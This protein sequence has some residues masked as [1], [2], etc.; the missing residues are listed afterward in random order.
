MA[1]KVTLDTLEIKEPE[2]PLLE[3]TSPVGELDVKEAGRWPVLRGVL[4][5]ALALVMVI[6]IGGV[7]YWQMAIPKAALPQ[8]RRGVPQAPKL[9]EGLFTAKAN[10]FIV[11]I[12]DKKGE[13]RVLVCD[14]TFELSTGQDACFQQKILPVRKKIYELLKKASPDGTPGPGFRDGLKEE[15]NKA[16][17]GLLGQDTIKA[18]YFTKFVVL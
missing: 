13:Y 11:T 4:I 16:V 12:Q 17:S 8:L 3:R 2:A 18:I 14:L 15:I 10:D 7:F 6:S 9:Q 1:K 5:A